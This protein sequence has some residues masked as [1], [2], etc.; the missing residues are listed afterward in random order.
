MELFDKC[1]AGKHRSKFTITG[2]TVLKYCISPFLVWCDAFAPGEERDP[3]NKYMHLLFERGIQHEKDTRAKLFK[4]AVEIPMLSFETGFKQALDECSKGAKVLTGAPL[5]FLQEDIYGVTDVIERREGH[6]SAFGGHYYVVKE[7]KSAKH[8]KHEYIM[9]C[10]FYTHLIGLIQGYTPPKFYLINREQEEFEYQYDEYKDELMQILEG[11]KEIFNGK[12]VSPTAKACKWPWESY[13]NK[14][15]ISQDD[16][17][18]V[19]NVGP[20]LK[21][22]LN[23]AGITTVKQLATQPIEVDVPE[24]TLKRIKL[25]AQAFVDKKPIVLSKPKLPKVEVELFMDF[26]GTDEL[27]TEEGMV[28]TDYLIGLLVKDKLGAH[29]RPFVAETLTDEGR[30]LHDFLAYIKKFPDA[31]IYHYGPYERTHVAALGQKYKIDVSSVLS[32]MIDVLSLVKKNVIF[33][34][35]TM[36]LKE[37]SKFLGFKY[38]GMADAQESIV[39][40]LQFLETKERE[41]LKRILDYNEDDVRATLVIKDYLS[42]L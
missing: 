36:S 22:K 15:A 33:P 1:V 12:K 5:F 18:I 26:E 35:M 21:K 3:E 34:T 13:C 28:K 6:K 4:G 29:F 37:V 38:R 10:A 27:E 31:P 30:M 7:I 17:S 42:G 23:A 32:R 19:P 20:A 41:L 40:Y 16:V 39:L 2:H 25:T 24:A 11:I 9:Q 8:I 14:A